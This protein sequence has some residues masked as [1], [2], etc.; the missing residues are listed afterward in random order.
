M[1]TCRER[2]GCPASFYHDPRCAWKAGHNCWENAA[3]CQVSKCDKQ[4]KQCRV[5]YVPK[6]IKKYH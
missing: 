5:F 2:K 6:K 3:G 1:F 4:C